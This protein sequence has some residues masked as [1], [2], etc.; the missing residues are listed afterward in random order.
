VEDSVT[1][2]TAG[3]AAGATVLGYCPVPDKED[4]LRSLGVRDTFR[5]MD[6]LPALIA[7]LEQERVQ[8]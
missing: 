4:E 7:K 2:T 8:G 3:L 5:R 6:E 1:G